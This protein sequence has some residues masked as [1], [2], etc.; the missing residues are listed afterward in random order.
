MYHIYYSMTLKFAW[1]CLNRPHLNTLLSIFRL[2]QSRLYLY[3]NRNY[4]LIIE[5]HTSNVYRKIL[6]RHLVSMVLFKSISCTNYH[7]CMFYWE[8][9]WHF[10]FL[11]LLRAWCYYSIWPLFSG[12][13]AF[14]F[15]ASQSG[16][17]F[18]LLVYLVPIFLYLFSYSIMLV[19]LGV[20][21]SLIFN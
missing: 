18:Q 7:L 14:P 12:F 20:H 15:C 13:F 17:K 16:S 8:V 10:L 21:V 5:E 9:I 6:L 2:F 3:L 4:F 11:C 1:K 19:L